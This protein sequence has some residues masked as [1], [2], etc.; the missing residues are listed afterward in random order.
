M[1]K[2]TFCKCLWGQP[3]TAWRLSSRWG[4]WWRSW[5]W[6]GGGPQTPDTWSTLGECTGPSSPYMSL[7][8]LDVFSCNICC[9]APCPVWHKPISNVNMYILYSIWHYVMCNSYPDK[10]ALKLDPEACSCLMSLEHFFLFFNF[11]HLLEP[12]PWLPER[13][14]GHYTTDASVQ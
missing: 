9:Q 12:R 14:W 6:P 1:T 11:P 8:H 3:W 13:L 7:G 5:S 10:L 4:S 2:Y